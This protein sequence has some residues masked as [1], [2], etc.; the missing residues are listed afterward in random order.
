MQ[1]LPVRLQKWMADIAHLRP[2]PGDLPLRAE[3]FSV[4]QLARH[5]MSLAAHHRVVTQQGFN[6]LLDRLGQNEGILRTFNRATLAVKPGRRITPAAEWLLDNF[7][8]IEE[9]IQMARRHLPRGYSRE[10]P[11]LLNGPN[12][13]LP[14]V[15]DI[16]LELISHVDAEIDA[17][18]LNAFIAAYQK[19]HPLK[20]GE[21]WAL[22]I[23]LRLGLIE[24]LQRVTTRLTIA[25][26][27]RDLADLWVD[28][29]QAM[30]E[31]DPSHL[32]IVVADM[33]KSDLSLSSS[34]VAEFCQR[35]SRQ[36]PVLH[37]ARGWLEQ[38]LGQQGL[39]I[40]QLIQ[41]DSQN[42]AADQV[43]VSHSITSLR[44]ISAMDWK[45]FVE[46]LSLVEATLQADPAG[47]YDAMDFSTRD[48]YRHAVEF[49]AR[50]SRLSEAEVAQRAI[51]VAAASARLKGPGDRT[52]HVGFYL[53]DKGQVQFARQLKVRLPWRTIAERSIQRLPLVFYVGGIGGLTLLATFLF[54]RQARA[55][56]VPGGRL[57]FF[58]LV[59]LPC[60]SQL[61][62]TLMNWLSTL[63]VKPCL[64]P[65]MDYSEGIPGGCRTMV[66]VPTMLT[67]VAGVDRLIETLEIHHL[68]N[69]DEYLHFALLTDFRDA[70][71]AVS[72][73]DEILLQRAQA[74][75]ELLNK[76]YVSSEPGRFF[77]FHR[78]RR[79]NAGEG[80]WM[81]YERKRGKLME[82]NALLRGGRRDC[83]SKIIGAT[84]ILPAV[85]YVITLDTDTQLPRE[86]ARQLVGTMAHPLNHPVFDDARGVVREG[87]SILQPRVGVS[88]PSARRSWFVRLFAGDAGIDPYTREVSDVYQ[89]VFQ[90]GS[91]IGKGIYD[92]DAFQ[93]AM[94][95][96]FPENTILSHDLLEACHARSALV[97][98]VE[99]YEEY[100]SRYDVDVKRRHRWIRGDW[101]ITQWLLPRVPG[102][103]SRRIINPLS[104]LSQ[105][106]IFDNLR[107][108]LVPPAWLLLLLGGWL[109]VPELGGLALLLVLGLIGLP[110][111]VVA[112]VNALRKPD[113][114]PWAM[115]LHEAA[116]ACSRQLGQTFL[117]LAFLAYDAFISADAI[118]KTVLRLL[119]THKRLLEWQTSSDSERTN[120]AD[121]ADFY[122]TMWM[123]PGMAL[124]AGSF[125]FIRHPV[126]L[127][128][129]LPLLLV[130]LAAPWI[131]WWI[132][133]PINSAAPEL[134]AGQA[135]FLRRTARLTWHFFDT[136]VSAL[137]NWLP[138]DNF[139]EIPAPTI[140]T[141]T[142]PTN[143]GL[144]LLAN[145]AARD[146]GYLPLGGLVKR[147]EAT[148]ATMQKLERHRGHFFNW[149]ETRTL[150]PLL[151]LY[152]SSVD[153]GN[154]AGHLLTLAAG[155]REQADESIF[156][157]QIF[158]GLRDTVKILK[159]LAPENQLLTELESEFEPAPASLSAAFA[160]LKKAAS[161]AAKIAASLAGE[162]K[163]TSRWAQI[164]QRDCEAHLAEWQFLAPWL[165]LPAPIR[166]RQDDGAPAAK[167]E[168]GRRT[169]GNNPGIRAP[170][171]TTM[172]EKFARLDQGLTLREVSLLD[173]SPAPMIDD[174]AGFAELSRCLREAADHA[175]QRMRELE[176]L[177]K[178]CDELAA[179]D[180]AFLFNPARDLFSTGFNLTERRFDTGF[181]DLLASEARLCSYVAIALG[182]VPQDHW[183][184]MGRLLVAS[185]G[186]PILVSWSGSMFEYLM[187]LLVMPNY[188]NTLL[189]HTC[190]A[191]V[192]QQIDYGELR[193]VPWGISESGYNRTDVQ[194]N[195]QYRAF[196]VPGLGLKRGLAED[197]VIAPYATVMALMV[198]PVAACE[199]LQ[200]LAAE[201][202][203]G[204]YGFHEAVDYT[205]ARL[206]PDE[207]SA[208]IR[209]FM[210]HHQGMSLLAL[211]DLLRDGPMQR[212]FLACPL[213]KA[214]DL[215]LQERVPKTAAS[216]FME[217]LK[218]EESR[219][220]SGE[221]QSV[222]RVLTNPTAPAPEVHLLS[223][224]RYHVVISSAGGGYSR[225]RELAVTRWREDATRDCWGTFVYLRDVG[226]GEFWSTSHQ[227]TLKMTKG[228]EAIFTQARAEFRHRQAGLEV[229][230]EIS[231]SPED[232]LEL[233]RITLT[234][235]SPVKREVEITSYSEVVLARPDADAAHP[236]F[237][238]L[239]VQTEFARKSSAI[240]CTRRARSQEERPPW[241]LH[242]MQIQSDDKGEISCETDRS[243]FVGRGG[244]LAN[245]AALQTISPLSN[246]VGAVLDPIVALR[247]TVTLPPFGTVIVDLVLGV[248]ENREA[249]LALVEK[250]QSARMTDRVLDLAWTHSQVTLHQL[251]IT[252]AEA[253]LYGRLAGALIYADPAR[254][255]SPG[256]LLNNRRGQN[257]LWSYG[258]SGDLPIALLRISDAEKIEIV[259]QLIQAHSYW[260]MK[261]LAVDLVIVNED[262]SVY[263]QSLQ[264]Q[265][266]TLISSGIEA[267]MM[268]KPGGIFVRRLEQIPNDDRVLLQAAA[269]LV[270]DDEKG[271]LAEQLEHRSVLEPS[272][273]L[274]RTSRYRPP[275]APAPLPPRELIFDN[276]FGGFTRD[277]H[278]Y[279]I[280][281]QPDQMTPAPWVNVL[282]NPFF[283][284]VISES[285]AA[286]TW[287]ENS[288]E[289]RLTPWSNDPVQDTTGEA[290]YIRDDQTGQ[291]W[292]PTPSPAR[293]GTPYV[294]RHGFGYT[295][296]E[297]TEYGIASELWVYVAIDA[298][299]KFSVLKLRNI[300]GRPR[301]LSVTGYMEWVLGDLRHKSLLHVQT[302]MD[303]K[304]GALLA[305]NYFNT[306]FSNRIVFLD[307]NDATATFTG[308][309]KE[310]IGRNGSL[311]QPAA[312]KRARL[313]GKVGAGLDPC[314]AV[315]VAVNL[316]AGEERET[317]FR[318]GVGRSAADV[319]VL[320]RRFRRA[321]AIRVALEAVWAYWNRTLGAVN[322][323]TPDPAVNVMANGWLMYQTLS[324]RLWGRTGFY[325]SGGA[326]GFRDQLQDVMAVVHCEP[327]L[328]REHLL[329]AAARQF[330]EGDVQHWWH[331]PSGRGVRTH[332]SDDFLW[333]PYVTCRYVS[334]VAD[335]GV[336]DEPIT[337]LEARTVK[338]EEESYYDLPNCSEESATLYQHCVRAIERGL[339]F[340]EHGL[341]LMGCGDWNDGMNLV[342][343]DGRGESVWLAFFLYDVL[344]Q[345]ARLARARND[346]AFAD[347]CL[348]QARQLQK[349]IELHAW[350]GQW[351][352]RAYFDNGEPLG[353]ET[354]PECQ[355]DSLPQS[356]SV[357]SGAGEPERSRQAMNAVD[358]RLVRRKTGLIQLFDPPFDKSML[359]PGYIKGYIPGVR[360][361][362]GQYTHGAIWTTMAF[363]LM[364]ENERAWELFTLLNPIHH[365]GTPT[366]IATY[367]VEPY[368]VAADVYAVAPHTGRGGWTWYTGSAGWM[369]RL[370]METLLGVNLE[371]DRL[372]LTPRLPKSWTTCKIHYRYRLTIYHITIT[373]LA[374]DAAEADQLTLDG[375]NLD[376]KTIPLVD[377][378][379]EH[380]VELKVWSRP[381]QP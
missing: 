251:D 373:P 279:V 84:T 204:A 328:A 191:A 211:V 313:S 267:Q 182:Q 45:A 98:D 290:F 1:T 9:Q 228:Y 377:D 323:D 72:P 167:A 166:R 32:V 310:F 58:T 376:V 115:H 217:D 237:S 37:L 114:L 112:L 63:L 34:F 73:G 370:L 46:S 197:L 247:R 337:F 176:A 309:R 214:A 95:G 165:A 139:Q 366:Q 303:L 13:G 282:A 31:K 24:N 245:P 208:T 99:F 287:V 6:S 335:T 339:K 296:F 327:A 187:P 325:Q 302:E 150:K 40:E 138:P 189:D 185:H 29:L 71:A 355:I 11:R 275:E 316:S 126:Q 356:W 128:F 293:G 292:S 113:D 358:Q 192:Q 131:A 50:N 319:Q 255:A 308:D 44:F 226:T 372:R 19:V 268:D 135:A 266:T 94:A 17:E 60:A 252:E 215:L 378:R 122:A 174:D 117:A 178:Q 179:M 281:L 75:I 59:F 93:R 223:N 103:D 54:I 242:L 108:S 264:D 101:Q 5:A 159:E 23:M 254:R 218:L 92:V 70:P 260:R 52:A 232:D 123:A 312:M 368:V 261:G 284:T 285:G 294:I 225:W 216:V 300:S 262:V 109:L 207:T 81:G 220:P 20:L 352:R 332:F 148:L 7:Y 121:L 371:G 30:A 188:E 110:G 65:R 83:F 305:R 196:G 180:F 258:I 379:R 27:D 347:R 234:N 25:R 213:L 141:R 212:R 145:L 304:T 48:R 271:T 231:V 253:Q 144:A 137:E 219:V 134:T 227:P 326:Y 97:C 288:H 289:F 243:R 259:R 127:F 100:P 156:T 118:C 333:L 162:E 168:N 344:T 201:G 200:R 341:P 157:P 297:H 238:N 151:P 336:L 64:L 311:A 277:G 222:M 206:P 120:R 364:G 210:A 85:K 307:V 43:S 221:G 334:C 246:T 89:D 324:C 170:A 125:L 119:V 360:E 209:S 351:Y 263:R 230:T 350:D 244:S 104:I 343:K 229:H 381:D 348:A 367:K 338:A 90:E 163:A 340:G 77:L 169:G 276:G 102:P 363:A 87:Y 369:Y 140:A 133:Q 265:I 236:A 250:Y 66:V 295:V 320:I 331:P 41:L 161:H 177:A 96:R 274:L 22:P 107:R 171:A 359:N 78:P 76:K 12:T 129:T 155:L 286:Y 183:F 33:A 116:R 154:L 55:L 42:Q 315:Q 190:R 61:A 314:G 193:G 317:C 298:P 233:R 47:V 172:A 256:V 3:L 21:L 26:E 105:W 35:L 62:V 88:L 345:F 241:L 136:F 91:F 195:Y 146:L 68:A 149:Y 111:L 349:N 240:L 248:T 80:L 321:D 235:R 16:V 375:E 194:L 53:I 147:T 202:R 106:K 39:S 357:I 283:G 175:R 15:Y 49:L 330:R 273:P 69:R 57:I 291:F 79:W 184:S 158:A 318:L 67:S 299:V 249:A 130:W 269:R 199:N 301:R 186:E 224:G 124:A 142:S 278:E 10:L 342:G 306:E 152:I 205:P 272:A 36:S 198:S 181:Y 365:G 14:R 4:E 86:A 380:F 28:R 354:N 270:L 346:P 143:L 74:G 160:W 8:L 173:Q 374:A 164:L 361:N 257:G 51:E 18:P 322:V 2:S 132:S 56:E 82:F 362:G 153:S 38:R 280:T 329:R 353:S 203:M 239:F